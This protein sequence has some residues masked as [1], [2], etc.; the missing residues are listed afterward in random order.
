MT[1]VAAHVQVAESVCVAHLA[2]LLQQES[3]AFELCLLE[4]NAPGVRLKPSVDLTSILQASIHH[5]CVLQD[6]RYG[7][8][9]SAPPGKLSGEMIKC[10]KQLR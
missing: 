5:A 7:L 8:A 6:C 10:T 2:A 3:T 4:G 1:T 9:V